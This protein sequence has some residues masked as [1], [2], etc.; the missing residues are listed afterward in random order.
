MSFLQVVIL[1]LLAFRLTRLVAWDE[2]TAAPRAA[3]SG[4]PDAKYAA[5]AK[6]I[7]DIRADGLDPWSYTPPGHT[8]LRITPRRY[9]VAKLLHCPWCVGFWISLACALVAYWWWLDIS[10]LTALALAFAL[11]AFVG[12]VAK[13]L[14]P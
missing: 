7:E 13:N 8:Q 2:L 4:V 10:L 5:L 14:D 9:Y 1:A 3:L 11:S 12:L 6:R